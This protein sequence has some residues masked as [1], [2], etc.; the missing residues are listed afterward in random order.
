MQGSC[1][2]KSQN[3]LQMGRADFSD[4]A[5]ICIIQEFFGMSIK[6]A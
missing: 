1:L 5:H 2:D 4:S 3:L 6:P